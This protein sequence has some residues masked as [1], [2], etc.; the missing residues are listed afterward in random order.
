IIK[1][2]SLIIL[3]WL[4]FCLGYGLVL[5]SSFQINHFDLFGLRQAWLYFRSKPYTELPF[6]TPFLY[7]YVRHPLYLGL[8]MAFWATPIMSYTRLLF[9]LLFTLYVLRAIRWEESDLV[10]VFGEKY[11]KY[12]TR[13]PMILPWPFRQSRNGKEPVYKAIAKRRQE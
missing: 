4:L 10:Q 9:A 2:P 5:W 6:K 13:V 7:R 11:R 12:K 1:E 3:C 8:L